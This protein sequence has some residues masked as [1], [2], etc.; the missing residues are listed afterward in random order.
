[1]D[2]AGRIRAERKARQV[3]QEAL[4]RQAGMSL[5]AL[6]SL[7]RGEAVDPHYSTL[8]GIADALGMSLSELLGEEPEPASPKGEAPS[9]PE[10]SEEERR[11]L[12]DL[13]IAFDIFIR[14]SYELTDALGGADAFKGGHLQE[15]LQDLRNEH[16][17]TH[18]EAYRML[19]DKLLESGRNALRASATRVAGTRPA[20]PEATSE[21][22]KEAEHAG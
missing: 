2:L 19:I 21:T 6:N 10:I 3:S 7:E 15:A 22:T 17:R 16:A 14:D 9:L 20:R 4:A 12:E 5:R 1:V 13:S 8:T 11:N 18:D